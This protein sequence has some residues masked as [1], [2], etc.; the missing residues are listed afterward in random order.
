M[1]FSYA[2]TKITSEPFSMPK[3][4]KILDQVINQATR[5]LDFGMPLIV[6]P[7]ARSSFLTLGNHNTIT[8]DLDP[9]F[10]HCDYNLTAHEFAVEIKG[11][12]V[13]IDVLVFD[14]P[15]S[16]RQVKECYEGIGK[17]LELW[18]THNMWGKCKDD[19]ASCM[20]LGSYA[21]SLGW[22]THG[23]GEKR[24]FKKMEIHNF[25]Q[26]GNEYAYNLLVTV[27]RKVQTELFSF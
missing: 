9:Q 21:V 22:D 8:N 23:M 11:S 4:R 10:T 15:Y 16:L 2:M 18:Q 26:G 19:L 5:E 7:F 1:K 6:D 12:G 27:E 24:G 13:E 17:D 3:V 25:E 20:K 14:P